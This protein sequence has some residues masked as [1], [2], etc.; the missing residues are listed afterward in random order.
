MPRQAADF[1]ERARDK[2][3]ELRCRIG[4]AHERRTHEDRVRANE[5]GR[6][7]LGASCDRRFRHDHT[8]TRRLSEE[9]ELCPPINLERRQVACVDTKD[10]GSQSRCTLDLFGVVCFDQRVESE[11]G[12]LG[13]QPSGCLVVEIAQDQQ[14]R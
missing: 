1:H 5:F 8:I 2:F 4:G 11:V 12:R 7:T 13:H 10:W 3:G 9:A 6:S 14:R